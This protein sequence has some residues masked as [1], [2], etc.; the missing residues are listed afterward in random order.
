MT[1]CLSAGIKTCL[2][3][4]G[5]C[6]P[7]TEFCGNCQDDDCD[8]LVNEDCA[9]TPLCDEE[10]PE[11][12]CPIAQITG[13]NPPVLVGQEVQLSGQSS[14]SPNGGIMEWAWGVHPHPVSSLRTCR[15]P[16]TKPN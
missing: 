7:P 11:L 5:P 14:T 12:L 9:S 1:P 3:D 16:K 6:I 13:L 15:S 8:G 4:W 10:E 2:K